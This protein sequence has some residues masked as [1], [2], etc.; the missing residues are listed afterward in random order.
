MK[1]PTS[2]LLILLVLGDLLCAADWWE[3]KPFTEWSGKQ[4]DRILND[5]PWAKIHTITIINPAIDGERTFESVGRGDLERE[6]RNLFHIRLLTAKPIRMA[7]ARRWLLNAPDTAAPDWLERFVESSDDQ[8][9]VLAMTVT[10]RPPSASSLNAY[11]TELLNLRTSDLADNTFLSTK[12]GKRVYLIRY[13][14]PGQDGLGAKYY[15]PRRLKDGTPVVAPQDR[16]VRFQ[17]RV[18]LRELSIGT[19]GGVLP[20]R[21]VSRT[22]KIRAVFKIKQLIFKGRQEI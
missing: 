17:T 6:K 2:I 1:K 9:I 8:H 7:S 13:E 10:S 11:T 4:V 18:T 5:S 16:E 21:E 22:D 20:P 19:T 14:P 3:E 15:F 12:T